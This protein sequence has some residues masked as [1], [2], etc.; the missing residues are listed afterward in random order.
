MPR[1]KDQTDTQSAIDTLRPWNSSEEFGEK[2]RQFLEAAYHFIGRGEGTS[3]WGQSQRMRMKL[4]QFIEGADNSESGHKTLHQ[5][6]RL[7][8]GVPGFEYRRLAVQAIQA[9]GGFWKLPEWQASTETR[10]ACL[11]HL[12]TALEA[13]DSVFAQLGSDLDSLAVKLD[14]YSPCPENAHQ[15]SAERILAELL[16]E[17]ADALG[18]A[19]EAREPMQAEILR[20]E[21]QLEYTNSSFAAPAA[22]VRDSRVLRKAAP[23]RSSPRNPPPDKHDS[24]AQEFANAGGPSRRDRAR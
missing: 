17:G 12:V 1:T 19:V 11:S 14:A 10:R 16:V 24:V 9:W 5:M 22:P 23:K 3:L 4:A 15:K 18:F 2:A 21:R 13:F 7:V 20:I 8:E 6:L